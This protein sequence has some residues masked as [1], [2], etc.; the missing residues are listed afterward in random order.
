M[1]TKDSIKRSTKLEY[2]GLKKTRH[3]VV[4]ELLGELLDETDEI[5]VLID[6]PLK[7]VHLFPLLLDSLLSDSRIHRQREKEHKQKKQT[8]PLTSHLPTRGYKSRPLLLLIKIRTLPY[9]A[10]LIFF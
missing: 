2:K 4:M 10:F 9:A 3:D 5:V 8:S 6:E 1:C 7:T